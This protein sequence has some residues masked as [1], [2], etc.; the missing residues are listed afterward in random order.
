MPTGSSIQSVAQ[1]PR[2]VLD[3]AQHVVL[4]LQCLGIDLG[5]NG[6]GARV[7]GVRLVVQKQAEEELRRALQQ[8]LELKACGWR[9]K[10]PGA[11][12]E[13]LG[14]KPS[15]LYFRMKKLG[16]KRPSTPI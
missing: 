13:R 11:A 14:L 16:I 12:A 4:L 1:Y 15:T 6:G 2:A 5:P 7:A 10:G 8:V 3:H 9:I